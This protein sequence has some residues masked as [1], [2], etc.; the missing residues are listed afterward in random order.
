MWI[1]FKLLGFGKTLIEL[2]LRFV[3][4][5]CEDW[6]RIV[7]AGLAVLSAILWFRGNDYRNERDSAR[8]GLES[9]IEAHKQTEV[10]YRTASAEALAAA[11][12][13]KVRV[14]T[15]YLE[16]ENAQDKDIRIR[17]TAALNSLRSRAASSNSSGSNAISL[18]NPSNAT[19]DPAGAGG[20]TV[21][22]DALICTANTI[23]TQGW[24]DWYAKVSNIAK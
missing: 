23:K 9:E 10:N 12:T 19:V 13:N 18:P 14:E 22:D 7:I 15:K 8:T 5:L 1:L 24:Q 21:M 11:K 4:W 17:L 20:D 16:I 2:G 6:L 3:A